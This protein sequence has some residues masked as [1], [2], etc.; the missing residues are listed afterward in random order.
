MIEDVHKLR[1]QNARV[2]ISKLSFDVLATIFLISTPSWTS[3]QFYRGPTHTRA[4]AISQVCFDWRLTALTL[5]NLW[6]SIEL[7]CGPFT[8]IRELFLRSSNAPF[9]EIHAESTFTQ[10]KY[11][12]ESMIDIQPDILPRTRYFNCGIPFGAL[13]QLLQSAQLPGAQLEELHLSYDRG[14]V[15]R[16]I[17][18]ESIALPP[19]RKLV[20]TET[21]VDFSLPFFS[22][23]SDLILMRVNFEKIKFASSIK[24]MPLLE[25]LSIGY[26]NPPMF[27][28]TDPMPIITIPRLLYLYT[29]EP[30]LLDHLD[31]PQECCLNIRASEYAGAV[32]KSMTRRFILDHTKYGNAWFQIVISDLDIEVNNCRA[33]YHKSCGDPTDNF[34]S[35]RLYGHSRRSSWISWLPSIVSELNPIFP[36]VKYLRV[37]Y[38]IKGV[39]QE[40]PLF[41]WKHVIPH[42]RRFGEVQCLNLGKP[43]PEVLPSLQVHYDDE[44]GT[45][46]IFP[47]LQT[48]H[49]EDNFE[50]KMWKTHLEPFLRSRLKEGVPIKYLKGRYDARYYNFTRKWRKHKPK[51]ESAYGVQLH[52][53]QMPPEIR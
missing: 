4:R 12:Y 17:L 26:M 11:F 24:N 22:N 49:V 15:R 31:I 47:F 39:V 14:C 35:L 48:Y 41:G 43:E 19:L 10:A 36:T 44:A 53:A 5:P 32:V 38:H 9:V 8:W 34:D 20:L 18:T 6:R 3:S 28:L 1:A 37:E 45:H 40:R 46:T 33:L 7:D 2:P 51:M 23:I 52:I 29:D 42:L 50:P 16:I 13:Q 27:A 30:G 21:E 25:R